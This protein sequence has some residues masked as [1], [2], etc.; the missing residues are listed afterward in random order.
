MKISILRNYARLIA[1]V[2]ANIQ[3]GQD[4]IIAC[5]LDSRNLWNCWRTNATKPAPGR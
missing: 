3:K 5:D 4:V 2:G 1:R